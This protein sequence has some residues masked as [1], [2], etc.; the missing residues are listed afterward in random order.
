M[1]IS[2]IVRGEQLRKWPTILQVLLRCTLP[3]FPRP[4]IFRIFLLLSCTAI[5]TVVSLFLVVFSPWLENG[6]GILF[7]LLDDNI[8]KCKQS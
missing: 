7:I 2:R 8:A 4:R 1:F 6:E 3:R 5:D